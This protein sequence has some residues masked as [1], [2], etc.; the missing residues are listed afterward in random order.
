MFVGVN[1]FNW[2]PFCFFHHRVEAIIICMV[3]ESNVTSFIQLFMLKV[4]PMYNY[5]IILDF[6]C[7]YLDWMQANQLLKPKWNWIYHFK[8][9]PL[10]WKSWAHKF[11][12]LHRDT[13]LSTNFIDIETQ[14]SKENKL[15]INAASAFKT[16]NYI[17]L[18]VLTQYHLLHVQ[19]HW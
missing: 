3:N 9:M 13:S 17:T 7:C 5:I 8:I 1:Q 4:C 19:R 16:W 10:I 11:H 14:I 6:P 12:I 18:H 15:Y 2:I